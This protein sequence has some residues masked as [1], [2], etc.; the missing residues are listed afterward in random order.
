MLIITADAAALVKDVTESAE[1]IQRAMKG[2]QNSM[3]MND[4]KSVNVRTC[5]ELILSVFHEH[6][7]LTTTGVEDYFDQRLL[8]IM[9]NGEEPAKEP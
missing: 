1:E 8:V 9:W 3:M 2:G 4:P 6:S 5:C 7:D